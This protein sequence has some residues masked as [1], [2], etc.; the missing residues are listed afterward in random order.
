[1]GDVAIFLIVPQRAAK[2]S[3]VLSVSPKEI[4]SGLVERPLRVFQLPAVFKRDEA[5][6][7]LSGATG[8]AIQRCATWC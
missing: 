8:E 4:P 6:H 5:R 2:S 7:S 3:G 1:M